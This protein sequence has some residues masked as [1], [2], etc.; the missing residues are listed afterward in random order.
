MVSE[1]FDG[2]FSL[3]SM[4]SFFSPASFCSAHYYILCL[5]S[6]FKEHKIHFYKISLLSSFKIL[7][8]RMGKETKSLNLSQNRLR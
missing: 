3:L 7:M 1:N 5:I 4:H 2:P 6:E 8:L